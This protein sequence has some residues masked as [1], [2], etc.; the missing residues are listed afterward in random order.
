MQLHEIY[1]NKD[2]AHVILLIHDATI[3]EVKDE[4]VDE[5]K[6][7]MHDVMVSVPQEVFPELIFQADVKVGDRL[8]EL[9]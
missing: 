8:G 1:K 7:V 9:T 6:E 3:L 2:Y 4:Y 5:V